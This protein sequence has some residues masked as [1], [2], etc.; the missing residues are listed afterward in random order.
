MNVLP[1]RRDFL[2]AFGP[3]FTLGAIRARAPTLPPEKLVVPEYF[4]SVAPNVK[5]STV[6]SGFA[7]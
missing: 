6:T 1:T 7:A 3:W 2:T 4:A 5:D